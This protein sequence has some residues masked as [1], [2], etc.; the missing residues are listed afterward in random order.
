M[1]RGLRSPR[2][3]A[4][5]ALSAH[6][7][8][9]AG[10][11]LAGLSLAGLS[12]AAPSLA[13]PPKRPLGPRELSAAD[14]SRA[15][16]EAVRAFEPLQ[17][18]E[19]A[20]LKVPALSPLK[21]PAGAELSIS[22]SLGQLPQ[23]LPVE[24]K[25][26]DGGRLIRSQ[27]V[28]VEVD[29]YVTVAVLTGALPAGAELSA[30]DVTAERARLS[31]LPQGV[32]TDPELAVGAKLRQGVGA[33]IPLR[34]AWLWVQPLIKRGAQVLMTFR[35]GALVITAVGEA[36]GDGKKGETIKLR[37]VQSNQIITGRVVAANAVEVEF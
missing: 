18:E 5:L 15:V 31:K 36:M 14:L 20:S 22:P 19:I 35:R 23:R 30:S 13:A 4:P 37:N 34:N 26:T 29:R 25:L 28:F 9:M 32:V 21:V 27:R 10:L 24:I 6:L 16:E 1:R 7:A 12:L 33:K 8:F 11:S 17:G 2:P 3:R